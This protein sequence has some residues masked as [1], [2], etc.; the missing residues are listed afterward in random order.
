MDITAEMV[1]ELRDR[2]QAGILDCKKALQE[3]NGNFEEAAELLRQKGFA[4]AEKK[5]DREANEGLVEAYVHA[6][7]NLVNDAHLAALAVEH[8]C[9][10][11]SYDAD[12]SRFDGIRWERPTAS[13]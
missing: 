8:R 5:A 2:T 7:G 12:F 9:E 13:A 10:I 1:K 4:A 3:A 6:G 11:V